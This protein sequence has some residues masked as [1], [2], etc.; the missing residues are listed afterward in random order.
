MNDWMSLRTS[1]NLPDNVR[2]T[3]R[4]GGRNKEC[5]CH[6]SQ[7]CKHTA[8]WIVGSMIKAQWT[9]RQARKYMLD[10]RHAGA[11]FITGQVD[12]FSAFLDVWE[13]C[14]ENDLP[15]Q[16][17]PTEDDKRALLLL[18]IESR[19][20][21]GTRELQRIVPLRKQTISALLTELAESELIERRTEG[22]RTANYRSGRPFEPL[23]AP[24]VAECCRLWLP[25]HNVPSEALD[26]LLESN[27]AAASE[28]RNR[29][30][31]NLAQYVAAHDPSIT[32]NSVIGALGIVP[33]TIE[34][35]CAMGES[36]DVSPDEPQQ[37][38]EP[39]NTRPLS[40]EQSDNVERYEIDSQPLSGEF[41]EGLQPPEDWEELLAS[42]Q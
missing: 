42:L 38:Q 2:K 30:T 17:E 31:R 15:M 13:H 27:D 26:W 5:A 1:R 20:G 41:S 18:Y 35:I 25:C 34:L 39:P 9:I 40:D 19:P 16:N 4:N 33:Q 32:R 6:G 8:Y 21:L 37:A 3:L 23:D 10:G 12:P 14:T 28:L 7:S 36:D 22:Q 29:F 24:R 11:A